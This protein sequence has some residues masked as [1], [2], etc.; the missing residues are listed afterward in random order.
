MATTSNRA[1]RCPDCDTKLRVPAALEGKQVTC[2]G[3]QSPFVAT[4]DAAN[5]LP[6]WFQPALPEASQP[7]PA[8]PP[9]RPAPP[10]RPWYFGYAEV[11]AYLWTFGGITL[12]GGGALL[13]VFGWLRVMAGDYRDQANAF[14]SPALMTG[15]ALWAA[16]F[17][18][19]QAV[20][21]AITLLLPIAR[22]TNDRPIPT[23]AA[24]P[25]E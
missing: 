10:R 11:I 21:M 15:L 13:T 19:T 6:D 1:Y 16:V 23:S 18:V 3:C 25:A 2:P 12:A 5:D 20:G 4:A 9:L 24:T 22:H 14:S 17:L 7:P 8:L